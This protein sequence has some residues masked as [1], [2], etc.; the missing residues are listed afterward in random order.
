MTMPDPERMLQKA[1]AHASRLVAVEVM[2]DGDTHGW[3]L[4]LSAV[5]SGEQ[6]DALAVLPGGGDSDIRL[7]NGQIPPWPEATFAATVGEQIAWELGVP[8]WFPSPLHPEDDCPHFVDR[9]RADPCLD[10]G[11][12]LVQGPACPWRGR[13]YQCHTALELNRH[14]RFVVLQPGA[15]RGFA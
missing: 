6:T 12:P 14:G 3:T 2:W 11:I 15:D 9:N 1:R 13:C 7:F 8:F 4:V 5:L 10:C